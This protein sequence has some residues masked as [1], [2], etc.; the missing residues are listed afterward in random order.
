LFE[1]VALESIAGF[2]ARIAIE[3]AGFFLQTPVFD[4][5][6]SMHFYHW[7]IGIGAGA[8]FV[9]PIGMLSCCRVENCHK[10]YRSCFLISFYSYNL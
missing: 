7:L 1:F 2:M 4:M 5:S 9:G 3:I 8:S 10:Y 6:F